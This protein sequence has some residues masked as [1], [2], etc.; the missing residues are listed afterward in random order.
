MIATIESFQQDYIYLNISHK[1][2][3]QIVNLSTLQ[4]NK[5]LEFHENKH[6]SNNRKFSTRLH[7]FEHIS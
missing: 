5:K 4:Y 3:F 7:L 2:I 1:K 6:D